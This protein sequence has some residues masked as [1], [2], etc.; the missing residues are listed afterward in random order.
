MLQ[1]AD[2]DV[3]SITPFCLKQNQPCHQGQRFSQIRFGS[4][5]DLVIPLSGQWS[6]RP[7]QS[8]LA[9]VEAGVDTLVAVHEKQP[10][11]RVGG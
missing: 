11:G 1:I 7:T 8:V 10:E 6:F 9:H 3:D 5:V 2:Y 4:Q